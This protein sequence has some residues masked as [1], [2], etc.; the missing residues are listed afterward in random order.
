MTATTDSFRTIKVDVDAPA[1]TITLNRPDKHN[2]LSVELMTELTRALRQVERAD[3]V[4]AVVITG[5]ETAFSTGADL[6]EAL[7]I[8]GSVDYLGWNRVWRSLT[9]AIERHLKPVIAAVN[10]YCLTGGLELA[11]ACDLRIAGETAQF[12]ITSAKIGSVAG[13]GGT[14]RLPR[15]VGPS[16]AKRLLFSGEF[17]DAAEALRIGLVDTVVPVAEVLPETR[18]L[19]E[20]YA[21]RGPLSLSWHKLAVNTGMNMDLESALDFEASLSAQAFATADK[22]EGMRAFLEKRSPRFQG[23]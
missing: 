21:Q 2:A 22:A 4:S 7:A 20:T 3:G 16:Q 17:I 6:N 15:L 9:S 11:L 8:T 12:G 13:A 18:R 5:A 23:R 14:Q 19:A 1:V 10:G